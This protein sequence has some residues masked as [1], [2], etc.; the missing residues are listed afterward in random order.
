MRY[1]D[2]DDDES[3][4]VK[5]QRYT[6]MLRRNRIK[7]ITEIK[8]KTEKPFNSSKSM[9]TVH[10]VGICCSHPLINIDNISSIFHLQIRV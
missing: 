6:T 9:K 8:T 1:D 4:P 5:D 2:D 3:S 10:V 7:M